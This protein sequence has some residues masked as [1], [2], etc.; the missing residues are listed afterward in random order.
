ML[1]HIKKQ[2]GLGMNAYEI[3]PFSFQYKDFYIECS[4]FDEF[5]KLMLIHIKN[6]Q[7]FNN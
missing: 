4:T 7:N 2:K 6:L 5:L 1:T 3:M